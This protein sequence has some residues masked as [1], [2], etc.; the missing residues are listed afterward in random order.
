M[1]LEQTQTRTRSFTI[2][3]MLIGGLIILFFLSAYNFLLAH[4]FAE[5]FTIAVSLV[6]FFIA[7]NA[8]EYYENS[9]FVFLGIGYL[10]V[11]IIDMVHTLAYKGMGVFPGY[12]ANLA[13]QMWI[14]GRYMESI[15]LLSA[16]FFLHRTISGNRTLVFWGLATAAAVATVFGGFFPDCYIEGQ[17]LT[18]FKKTSELIIIVI[19]FLTLYLLF[20][21]RKIFSPKVIVYLYFSIL[22][23]V[24][25][26]LAFIMYVGVYD[27]SNLLGHYFKIVSFYLIY[28]GVIVTGFKDPYSFLMQELKQ[29][30]EDLEKSR[31]EIAYSQ[32]ITSTMLDNIPEEVVL[33]DTN[34]CRIIDANRTFLET[35][36][37]SRSEALKKTCFNL[38]H[39]LLEACSESNIDCPLLHTGKTGGG[40][41][42]IVHTHYDRDGNARFMEVSVLPVV[43]NRETREEAVYIARDITAHKRAEQLREDVERVVRHDLKSPLNGI[44]GGSKLMMF[45]RN[46]SENQKKMLEAIHESSLTVLNMVD[47]SLDLY[48]MEEGI[49]QLDRESFD[50]T[51]VLR[52][53]RGQL[54]IG[55]LKKEMSLIVLL[56][57]ESVDKSPPFFINAEKQGIETILYNLTE[58]AIEASPPRAAVTVSVA[59]K[60]G[61]VRFDIHNH[62]VIPPQVRERFFERYVTHGKNHGTGLGT[63]SASMITQAHGGTVEFTSNEQE[64]T[65]L[66]VDIPL[67]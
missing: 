58:N 64:G 21:N 31:D 44:I 43:H 8:R 18:V 3:A 48:K 53:M 19:L 45:D 11:G 47:R 37:I 17:G 14:I 1:S 25:A 26:E 35:R 4:A 56:N 52:Q 13:T 16:I 15:A 41:R 40:V 20:R 57:G 10:F 67:L 33:L 34:T 62:G 38:N 42:P 65:H 46:L 5:I 61:H 59:S 6:I 39:N 30:N 50:L 2:P 60:E 49:Y 29:K 63:Y 54:K 55:K 9:Y 23:T 36:D 32:R 51:A 66:L 24:C 28:R 22:L 27:I 12:G 7:W